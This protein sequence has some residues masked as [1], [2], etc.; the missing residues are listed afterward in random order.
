MA[1]LPL[2]TAPARV[3]WCDVL[4]RVDVRER[5]CRAV[6]AVKGALAQGSGGAAA[7]AAHTIEEPGRGI[8]R[9]VADELGGEGG[10]AVG[11][12]A[13]VDRSLDDVAVARADRLATAVRLRVV[14][15]QRQLPLR[16]TRQP[17]AH[18]WCAA[19]GCGATPGAP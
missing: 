5:H 17:S 18:T 15:R 3:P 14:E 13:E 7:A 12:R 11:E 19:R 6:G 2:P 4:R 10:V 8:V 9:G 1:R 16:R